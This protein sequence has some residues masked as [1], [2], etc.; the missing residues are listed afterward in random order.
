MSVSILN[1]D[2]FI[3]STE[4]RQIYLEKFIDS[5]FSF[6]FYLS[7]FEFIWSLYEFS[8]ERERAFIRGQLSLFNFIL[9]DYIVPYFSY[10]CY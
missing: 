5:Y 7:L 10:L 3:L 9:F 6:S 2:L 4:S 1:W 8:L